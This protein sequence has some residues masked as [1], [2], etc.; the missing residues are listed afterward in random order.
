M[1]TDNKEV[2]LQTQ[3]V[4]PTPPVQAQNNQDIEKWVSAFSD[5]V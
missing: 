1:Q 2:E 3:Q 4:P 5:C